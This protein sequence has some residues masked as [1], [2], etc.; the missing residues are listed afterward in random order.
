MVCVDAGYPLM[1]WATVWV[2]SAE[3]GGNSL[4]AGSIRLA[5]IALV[6][7]RESTGVIHARYD[8]WI[9]DISVLDNSMDI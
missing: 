5:G 7:L 4:K 9:T 3:F 2:G 8:C 6:S 1:F